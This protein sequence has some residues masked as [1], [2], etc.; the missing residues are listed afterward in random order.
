MLPYITIWGLFIIEMGIMNRL[1]KNIESLFN[2]DGQLIAAY[3]N[4]VLRS[5]NIFT[6][7][8]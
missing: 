7:K 6:V 5:L 3:G 2:I 1:S 8:P 4:L